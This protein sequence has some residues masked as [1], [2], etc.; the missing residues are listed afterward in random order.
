MILYNQN[1]LLFQVRKAAVFPKISMKKSPSKYIFLLYH[2]LVILI[3][4]TQIFSMSLSREM[5]SS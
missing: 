2:N 4:V 3:A 1:V 5:L